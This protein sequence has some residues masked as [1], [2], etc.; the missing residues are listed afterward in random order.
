[1]TSA[2]RIERV[3]GLAA[4]LA[5]VAATA[6]PAHALLGFDVNASVAGGLMTATGS[7]PAAG[8][9]IDADI[10]VGMPLLPKLGAHALLVGSNRAVEATL[11]MEPLPLPL[12]SLRPGIGIQQQ[13]LVGSG[14]L[15]VYAGLGASLGVPLVPVSLDAEAGIGY[16]PGGS[17]TTYGVAGSFYPLPLVPVGLTVKARQYQA[18]TSQVS[19]VLAGLRLSI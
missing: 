8:M 13:D 5:V 1:M 11:R 12:I 6:A 9:P 17:V 16:G 10:Y 14:G 19:A 2:F 15:G 3:L 18:A 4:G 7:V